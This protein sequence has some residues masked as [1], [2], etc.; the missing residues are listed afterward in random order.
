[1]ARCFAA[2]ARSDEIT[3][4]SSSRSRI[5]SLKKRYRGSLTIGTF[6]P[7]GATSGGVSCA[8]ARTTASAS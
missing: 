1:L 2:N 8:V 3:R 5:G 6:K 7:N 4:G